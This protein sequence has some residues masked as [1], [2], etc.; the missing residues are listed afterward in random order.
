MTEMDYVI[1]KHGAT[2]AGKANVTLQRGEVTVVAKDIPA[3][4]YE[5][6]G[7]YNLSD[8]ISARVLK[9]AEDAGRLGAEIEVLRFVAWKPAN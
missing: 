4:V 5:N 3:E 1:R 7:E 2:Q 9:I 6:C 8:D